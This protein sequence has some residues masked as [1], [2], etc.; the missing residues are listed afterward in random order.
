MQQ[1][2]LQNVFHDFWL[3]YRFGDTPMS[4][5]FEMRAGIRSTYGNQLPIVPKQPPKTPK[6]STPVGKPIPKEK[7][8]AKVSDD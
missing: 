6:P 5:G 1:N 4:Y 8:K 7:V 2:D 3:I